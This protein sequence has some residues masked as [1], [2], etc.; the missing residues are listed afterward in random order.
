MANQ[1]IKVNEEESKVKEEKTF[2]LQVLQFPFIGEY[3][4]LLI[5]LIPAFLMIPLKISPENDKWELIAIASL[6]ILWLLFLEKKGKI[7]ICTP[8]IP[9]PIK[10]IL[11]PLTI[12]LLFT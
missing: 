9:I 10:W 4:T 3:L 8:H 12:I 1:N 6:T 7:K 11:I 5:A 2:L